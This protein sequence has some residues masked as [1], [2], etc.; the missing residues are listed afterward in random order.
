[1]TILLKK[2][3]FIVIH[4]NRPYI[5]EKEPLCDA[6]TDLT[7]FYFRYGA[8]FYVFSYEKEGIT[9]HTFIDTGD[10]EYEDRILSILTENGIDPGNIERIIITHRHHD[11]CGL[12]ELLAGESG[13]RIFVHSNF[14]SFVEGKISQE[15][16]R[17][18]G[19][20]DPSSLKNCK[21][22]YLT[23]S[24]K[25]GSISIDGVDFPIMVKPIEIGA[26][27][28]LTILTCPESTSMHSPDQLL[29]LYSAGKYPHTFDMLDRK[30]ED[31]RP[32][33]DIFFSGDLWLMHG[34]LFDRGFRHFLRHLKFG[35][36]RIRALMSGRGMM[37]RDPREQDPEAKEALKKGFCMI[38]VKPGHGREFLG[39]RII[40]GS[41]HADR[42]LLMELGYPMDT[43]KSL[44][45]S[46][47]LAPKV[48]DIREGAY[49]GFIEE[50]LLWNKMGYSFSEMS[51]LLI[52]VYKE[53]SGGGPLVEQDRKERR[54]RIEET[55]TSL[56]NDL[57]TSDELRSFAESTLSKIESEFHN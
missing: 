10:S 50:V 1:M 43:D 26:D 6:G 20:F 41:F 49:A 48:A 55:L 47:D 21:M 14:K 30:K 53:Q 35:F 4:P 8:N 56:K 12:T 3:K 24:G 44:L 37:W 54:E 17:W 39:S 36:Y 25:N 46:A 16:R 13:A 42:D 57:D 31:L 28:R 27:G 29:V 23:P 52:R 38:R 22:E 51:D 11:H 5:V 18:L 33:D 34:P 32:A 7:S 2:G 15:E 19:K 45:E 40:P 9:R